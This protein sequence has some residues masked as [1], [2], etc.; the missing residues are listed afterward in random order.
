[1]LIAYYDSRDRNTASRS[2]IG[3]HGSL[4]D[5]ESRVPCL[6]IGAFANA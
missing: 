6:R 3:Q 2:M 4:T 5:E 1:K